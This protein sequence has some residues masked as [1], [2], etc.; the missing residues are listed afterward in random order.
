VRAVRGKTKMLVITRKA[1]ESVLIGG[2]V[3]IVV[4]EIGKDKVKFGVKAPRDVKV[5][6]SELVV[7]KSVNVEAAQAV[8]KSALDG[9]MQVMVQPKI[10]KEGK[11]K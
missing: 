3:E 2:D 1:D 9:L 4:L 8:S 11:Q 7:A 5:M 6:R 10:Q